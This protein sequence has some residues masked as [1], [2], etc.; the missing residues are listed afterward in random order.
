MPCSIVVKQTEEVDG[1][2]RPYLS[3]SLVCDLG[4]HLAHRAQ[5]AAALLSHLLLDFAM[6]TPWCAIECPYGSR[7]SSLVIRSKGV[8]SYNLLPR[9]SSFLQSSTN[10]RNVGLLRQTSSGHRTSDILLCTTRPVSRPGDTDWRPLRSV[11]AR[12]HIARVISRAVCL[13]SAS[14]NKGD[15]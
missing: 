11:R 2:E 15:E 3:F 13:S 8:H 1:S 6:N 12:M 14:W 9:H 4:Q 7:A 5:G 10:G